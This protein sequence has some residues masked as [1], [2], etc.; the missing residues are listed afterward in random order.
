MSAQLY[1]IT[2]EQGSDFSLPV[3]LLTSGSVPMNLTGY[4]AKAEIRR[5]Y[6]SPQV[7]AELSPSGSMDTSGQFS[8]VLTPAQ[9]GAL[10]VLVG[11]WDLIIYSGTDT[12]RLLSGSATISPQVTKK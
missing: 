4:Q 9:T 2:I 12:L 6:N 5:A 8:L 3:T 10:P 11:V 7:V 1:N